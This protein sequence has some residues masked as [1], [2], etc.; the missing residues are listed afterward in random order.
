MKAE[1]V[2]IFAHWC[3]KCNLMMPVIDEIEAEYSD[4]FEVTRIEVTDEEEDLPEKYGIELVPTFII[5]KEQ[6]E[7]GRMSGL[8][9]K[10]QMVQRIWSVL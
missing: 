9:S 5:K 2:V 3:P 4:I 6:E 8:I 10:E 7:L 1:L